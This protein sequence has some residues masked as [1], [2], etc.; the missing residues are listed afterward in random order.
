MTVLVTGGAGYVGAHM[1]LALRDAGEGAVA[2]DDLSVGTPSLVPD[3]C[4]LVVAD[5]GDKAAVER[6]LREYGVRDVIHFAGSIL[7]SESLAR[8]LAYY[9]NNTAN[10]LSLLETCAAN[11]V[12][13]FIYSS[14]AAVYGVPETVPVSETAPIRPITPYGASMAMSERML[15]DAAAAHRIGFAIL[16]Y[17]NVAGA[18]PRG[19]AGEIGKPTHLIKVAAQIAVGVRREK[20]QIYG[21]DYPT[22][23]GTAIRDYVHVSD[24]AD[25]HLA[26]LAR[27][28]R[29]GASMTL[30]VGYGRGSSV[31]EV[32]AAVER[33][34][35][36]AVPREI[37]ARRAGDPSQ[38]IADSAAIRTALDWRPHYD[39]LD[40]IVRTAIDWERRLASARG[41]A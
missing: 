7:V 4:P 28:R 30:N 14:T 22:P 16:R 39:D 18:D 8:P 10:T 9:R 37:V 23:D 35:K 31:L 12:E 1:L 3:G 5:V 33:V 40:F 20:L 38:L 25:A 26:A 21:T 6:V 27:L 24:I 36:T 19:R 13:R 29:G 34:A 2:L 17:F 11:G 32:V 41:S 15:V